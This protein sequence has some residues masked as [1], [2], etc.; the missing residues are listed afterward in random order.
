MLSHRANIG[1]DLSGATFTY[2]KI[3]EKV[4]TSNSEVIE[5]FDMVALITEKQPKTTEK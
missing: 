3:G 1:D 4:S 5:Y 2:V